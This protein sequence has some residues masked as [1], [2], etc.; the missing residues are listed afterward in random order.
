MA[1]ETQ[2]SGFK[3]LTSG[4]GGKGDWVEMINPVNFN[5][6]YYHIS[7]GRIAEFADAARLD[8]AKGIPE[9]D[10][11]VIP[12]LPGRF[13]TDAEGQVTS[14]EIYDTPWKFS[15]GDIIS[16]RVEDEEAARTYRIAIRIFK[17]QLA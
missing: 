1:N 17:D 15:T 10:N 8:I 13:I 16:M 12:D 7:Y 14:F 3:T 11:I 5:T 2:T 4:S 9:V 6:F